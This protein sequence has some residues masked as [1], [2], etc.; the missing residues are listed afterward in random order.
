MLTVI[1]EDCDL[2]DAG[3]AELYFA[4]FISGEERKLEEELL[5]RL[6]L[7]VVHDS[8]PDLLLGLHG[9]EGQDLIHGLVVLALIGRAV[10]GLDPDLD[11]VVQLP[12]ATDEHLE[13]ADAFHDRGRGWE[14]EKVEAK[15]LTEN[16]NLQAW[17]SMM[18][19]AESESG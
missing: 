8:D 14:G 19:L 17:N 12:V 11:G 1:V 2:H 6:P 7:V 5:V 13:G 4:A 3:P 16:N 10:N 15:L 9:L 18:A